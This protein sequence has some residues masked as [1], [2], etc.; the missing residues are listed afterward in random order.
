MFAHISGL[1]AFGVV[2]PALVVDLLIEHLAALA[3][4]LYHWIQLLECLAE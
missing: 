1:A 4:L 2:A 3:E